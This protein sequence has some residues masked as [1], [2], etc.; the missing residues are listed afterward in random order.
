[1]SELLL[2]S[3][4]SSRRPSPLRS[5]RGRGLDPLNGNLPAF[6]QAAWT[7]EDFP[8]ALVLKDGASSSSLSA[9]KS[10]KIGFALSC[11]RFGV[12]I[13]SARGR[14]GVTGL[15]GEGEAGRRLAQ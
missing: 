9:V 8:D 2:R 4:R 3:I 12:V 1:M 6:A 10:M 7:C 11:G 13:L 14:R 5:S 15:L